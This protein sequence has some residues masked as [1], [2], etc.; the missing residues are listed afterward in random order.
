M[1]IVYFIVLVGVLVLVHELGHLV[2]AKYFGVR[3]LKVSLG[4]GPRIAGFWRGETEYVLSALPLGGYVRMLGENPWDDVRPKDIEQSFANLR[5][6]R[7]CVIVVAG[8]LMNLLFPILLY[9]VVYLGDDVLTPATVGT[10]FPD[11][12]ADGKLEPGDQVTAI[13]DKPI[14]TFYDLSRRVEDNPGKPLHFHVKRGSETLDEVI[15]PV[16]SQRERP[17]ERNEE[18][19]RVGVMPH[20]PLGVVGITSPKSPAS[21][22][23]LRTF[24]LIVSAAGRPVRRFI[25][26]EKALAQ[27]TSSLIPVTYLRPT[28]VEGALGGLIDLD[29]YEPRLT[30]VTPEPGHGSMLERTGM[31]AADLY[32]SDV[33]SGSPEHHA[34]L[35]PGDRL[36]TLDG[37]PIRL[38]AT[39]LEDLKAER[40]KLHSL[41]WRRGDHDLSGTL[42]LEHQRG[43]TEEGQVY[44]R[45]AVGMRNWMPSRADAPVANP[46][47]IFYS[48]REA[49]RATADVVQLTLF[50]VVRLFQ[51]R[52]T[53]KS[54]GG[55]LTVFEVTGT[56]A[57]QGTLNYL[58]LMAFI[59]INLGLI[60]LLPVPLLD[61]GHL[62]FFL[63]EAIVRRPVSIRVREYA[64][65]AGLAF[66][67]GI[68]IL[69][70]KNDIER[71][72]PEIVAQ[73]TGQ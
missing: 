67:V 27:N 56:A 19:G 61:G 28:S 35:L 70:F 47:P 5:L 39:F 44:D 54:I 62:M 26:L 58:T 11:R 4:F 50:S 17:L 55:P 16:S 36:L 63:V 6:W 40:G 73:M 20:H 64:H 42:S 23:R 12:P 41:T 7:R 13:D 10:V 8:P 52:L 25:D 37:R 53:M 38:W 68:M 31:E 2:W 51:G 43:V 72:W 9:F 30:T 15:T 65:I 46:E 32:V 71:Q 49:F 45:Y 14:T 66:L 59:S 34:G 18:V 1:P 24:D 69:A 33:T 22:G 29:I 48:L 60:N 3:V 21:A 57:Q